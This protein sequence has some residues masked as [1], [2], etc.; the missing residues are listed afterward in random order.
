MIM[1]LQKMVKYIKLINMKTIKSYLPVFN[2]FYNTWFEPDYAEINIME[3]Y[4]NL[5]FEDFEFDYKDYRNR[6]SEAC[7][8]AV[9]NQLKDLFDISIEFEGVYSPREYNFTNDYINVIYYLEYG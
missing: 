7:V 4:E 5:G 3:E 8:G 2:G 1:I 6:V 9:E